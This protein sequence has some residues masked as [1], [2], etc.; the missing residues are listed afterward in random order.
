MEKEYKNLKEK[1]VSV[2]VDGLNVTGIKSFPYALSEI[3]KEHQFNFLKAKLIEVFRDLELGVWENIGSKSILKLL[4]KL[5]VYAEL[6]W[7]KNN[8]FI[9]IQFKGLFFVH[10]QAFMKA[11]YIV[12]D[13]IAKTQVLFRL[14]LL[15]VA[16]DFTED[17]E[18]IVPIVDE[19]CVDDS[20]KLHFKHRL[21]KY[22]DADSD[23]NVLTGF[24]IIVSRTKLTFYNKKF[25][26]LKKETNKIKREHYEK[27]FQL[28]DGLPFSRV[29]LRLKQEY[30]KQL[31]TK[32][33]DPHFSALELCLVALSKYYQRHKLRYRPSG[34]K[35][36]DWSR[37]PVLENWKELFYFP[38]SF[39]SKD[40]GLEDLVLTNSRSSFDRLF[41]Q[42]AEEFICSGG[43]SYL[44]FKSRLDGF[45]FDEIR[46][47]VSKKE[48]DELRTEYAFDKLIKKYTELS[49]TNQ[50]SLILK[51]AGPQGVSLSTPFDSSERVKELLS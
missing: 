9:C 10:P 8:V 11:K 17:I 44:E 16:Q 23:K 5:G 43:T 38:D 28:Y 24:S 25:E 51:E 34:R 27:L 4:K 30:L 15:D 14:T 31:W 26:Q 39:V 32:F 21:Q 45:W 37:L 6:S 36:K 46:K 12:W 35:D 29:E 49:E 22:N 48:H 2:S 1:R 18:N 42:L 13:C 3:E 47:R 40:L 41:N 20:F 33:L 7:K 19:T 50:L